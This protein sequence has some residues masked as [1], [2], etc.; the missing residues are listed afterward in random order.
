VSGREHPRFGAV[1]VAEI[2]PSD[3]ANPPAIGALATLC[4]QALANYKSP[5]SYK[6]VEKI[7][8]TASGK[9]QR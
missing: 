2:E 8:R 4:R 1:P 7:P 6:F 9:I 5:V 3:P